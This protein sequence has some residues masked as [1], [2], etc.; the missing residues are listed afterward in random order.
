[1]RDA[2]RIKSL[3][4]W[5]TAALV[6][7]ACQPPVQ[8]YYPPP[9]VEE[10]FEVESVPVVDIPAPVDPIVIAPLE[11]PAF[12]TVPD[13]KQ[14]DVLRFTFPTPDLNRSHYGDRPFT[15]RPGRS[16]HSIIF[17]FQDPSP[18]T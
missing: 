5:L 1:M 8:A 3:L 10:V 14:A 17:I 15:K 13:E 2:N 11:Q 16:A 9:A 18:Q 6:L 4:L 12:F 7:S